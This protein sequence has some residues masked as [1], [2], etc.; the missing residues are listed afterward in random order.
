MKKLFFLICVFISI[1]GN[2]QNI[3]TTPLT[4]TASGG[5]GVT[6][7][8]LG[9]NTSFIGSTDNRSLLLYSN[10]TLGFKIDSIGKT[11]SYNTLKIGGNSSSSNALGFWLTKNLTGNASNVASAYIDGVVQSDAVGTSAYVQAVYGT[12]A[13]SFTAANIYCFD[14]SRG[15]IGAGSQITNLYGYHASSSFIGGTTTAGFAGEI[16]AATGRYN[17]WM[18]GTAQNYFNGSIG[19]ATTTPA[20]KLHVVGAGLITTSLGIG[21]STTPSYNLDVT[22]NMRVTNT[23]NI[24]GGT[25][26]LSP[27]TV[28]I[29]NAA[30]SG[31][32]ANLSDVYFT[33]TAGS[34]LQTPAAGTTYYI[35]YI[36]ASVPATAAQQRRIYVPYNCTL[37]GVELNLFCNAD[38]S[39]ETN[40]I[41]ILQNNSINTV[42][43]SAVIFTTSSIKTTN[44]S[45]TGLNVSFTAGDYYE[46]KWIVPTPYTT[47]PTN[48]GINAIIYFARKP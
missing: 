47:P 12:Q 5:W 21:A 45:V 27:N 41:S 14:A 11:F 4:A 16:P 36:Y 9:N 35:G 3:W 19:I 17:C 32:Q 31:T 7:N 33:N 29:T 6:G 44:Y 22:G 15:T 37:V 40:T 13:T 8:A 28:T 30:S 25:T 18:N 20:Q 1:I 2:S 48:A 23:V 42:L 10:N 39:T 46:I 43:S 26:L 34:A 24:L 38:A